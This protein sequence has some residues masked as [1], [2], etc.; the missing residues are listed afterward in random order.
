MYMNMVTHLTTDDYLDLYLFAKKIG[1]KDW[2]SEIITKLRNFMNGR[3]VE[4]QDSDSN[5]L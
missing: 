1:D 3:Q 5:R 4:M 2:Q